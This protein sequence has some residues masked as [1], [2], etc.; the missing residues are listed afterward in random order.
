MKKQFA[1]IGL[2][3]FGLALCEELYLHGE[4][5]LAIDRN[6]E[7]VKLASN[8]VSQAIVAD[9]SHD[10]VVRE[11]DLDEF[12]IVFVAIGSDIYASILTT[13]IL[14]EAGAK[15]VWVKADDRSHEFI[16]RKIGAD[17]VVLPEK[18]MG[19]QTARKMIHDRH[20]RLLP[21][22]GKIVLIDI[23][24][25][26]ENLRKIRSR[27][28]GNEKLKIIAIKRGDDVITEHCSSAEIEL[29]DVLVVTG[30]QLD[31]EELLLA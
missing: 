27:I 22:G 24:V 31:V 10:D 2:G 29:G 23:K 25:N 14:K 8:M 15:K 28:G 19:A 16:L 18:E 7:R 1:V 11:L 30:E 21:L 12:D 5:I 26:V 17:Y 3:R 9:A 6:E 13:L 20:Y 4:D